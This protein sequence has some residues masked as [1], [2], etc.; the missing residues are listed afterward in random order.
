MLD[1][2]REAAP[3]SAYVGKQ[4]VPLARLD[5]LLSED[6]ETGLDGALLKIDAQG[7]EAE[8][9]A[10]AAATLPRCRAVLIEMSSTPL[11]HGQALWDELHRT[12]TQAGFQ[13]FDLMPD[14]RDPASG[15]LLQ[16]DGLYT[17]A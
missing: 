4:T 6:A 11:Y 5:T 12:L 17:R 13:L 9:L 14:F 15:R 2:H 16:F 3:R 1:T 7:F 8:V 10:G